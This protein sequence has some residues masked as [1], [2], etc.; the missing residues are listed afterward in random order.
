M[1]WFLIATLQW[2]ATL[3]CMITTPLVVLLCDEEGELDGI[4]HLWQ[5]WDD[6]CYAEQ[7][8]TES[9]PNFLQRSLK[10]SMTSTK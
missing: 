8:A 9:A 6:S 2:V 4:F 10:A 5:T 7:M 3:F 1:K